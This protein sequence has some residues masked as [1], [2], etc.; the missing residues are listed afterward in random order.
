[1]QVIL[2]IMTVIV[3]AFAAGIMQ[4]IRGFG[5]AIVMI[6]SE[7]DDDFVRSIFLKPA[8]S[9]QEAFDGAMKKYGSDAKVISMPFGGATLPVPYQ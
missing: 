4:S 5:N 9:G 3:L 7:M 2:K 6:V 8:H 1:M